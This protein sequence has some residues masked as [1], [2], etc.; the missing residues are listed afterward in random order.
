MRATIASI[1]LKQFINNIAS[2][3]KAIKNKVKICL[4]I[5]NNAYG[6]GAI[7]IAK[8]SIQANIDTLGVVTIGEATELRNAGIKA[9]ILLFSI[10]FPEELEQIAIS[11]ITALCSDCSYAKDLVAA[12]KKTKKIIDVHIKIDTGMGRLGC[13]L[14]EVLSLA[15]FIREQK[16][17]RLKGICTHFPLAE[18][19]NQFFTISQLQSFNHI[20]KSIPRNNLLTRHAANSAALLNLEESHLDMVRPGILTYGYYPANTQNK[21]VLVKPI[22]E[23]STKI[24]FLKKVPP[25]TGISYGLKYRTHQETYIATLPVGYGDGLPRCLSGIAHVLVRGR[26]YPLVGTIC[27]DHSMIDVGPEPELALYDKAIIFGPDE[28]GP[29][30]NELAALAE[31]IPYE[32]TSSVSDRVPRIYIH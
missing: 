6:H 7:E 32:I 20:I 16:E 19:P 30:A 22:M 2:V 23:F 24:I 21:S 10:A 12:A 15:T 13:S 29:C 11:D 25:E 26:R 4:M 14:S 1:N 18:D 3:R 5:K 8:A 31:T 27:M 28:R 9:P 17:L